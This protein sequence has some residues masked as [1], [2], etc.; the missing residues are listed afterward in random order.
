MTPLFFKVSLREN[1]LH[2]FVLS[3]SWE[4]TTCILVALSESCHSVS[5]SLTPV[6]LRRGSKLPLEPTTMTECSPSHDPLNL[7]QSISRVRTI[8]VTNLTN[9]WMW[10]LP[11]STEQESRLQ[12]PRKVFRSFL[13]ATVHS[14]GEGIICL[15][16]LN[17][18]EEEIELSKCL[19]QFP[20]P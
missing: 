13:A 8:K 15:W 1:I 18:I 10:L 17:G 11:T 5:I 19:N 20:N 7:L 3:Q 4:S 14:G 2:Y 12:Y 16:T 9:W 6:R